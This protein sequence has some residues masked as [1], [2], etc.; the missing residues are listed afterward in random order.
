MVGLHVMV[1][2]CNPSS[3]GGR[4]RKVR[5]H[6]WPRQKHKT[7]S[8]K[9][10]NWGMVQIVEHVPHRLKTLSSVL[11]NAKKKKL[12]D[13]YLAFSASWDTHLSPELPCNIS[14]YPEATNARMSI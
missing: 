10:K 14:G 9:Q 12:E 7:L 4:G 13:F 3:L 8:G 6:G 5:V 2:T 1:H 11:N